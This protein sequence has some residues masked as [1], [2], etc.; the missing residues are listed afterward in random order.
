[1]SNNIKTQKE[2][3]FYDYLKKNKDR[4]VSPTEIGGF[5]NGGHSAIASP[6][7]IRLTNK[8]LIERNK[9]GHYKFIE[10]IKLLLN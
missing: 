8:G 5:Y 7:L 6:V 3:V 4:F 2:A 1:M 10:P 9:K